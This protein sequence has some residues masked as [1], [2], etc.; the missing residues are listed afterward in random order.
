MSEKVTHNHYEFNVD[1]QFNILATVYIDW[2]P[3]VTKVRS[4]QP[5]WEKKIPMEMKDF[6]KQDFK[7]VEHFICSNAKFSY[8]MDTLHDNFILGEKKHLDK[9]EFEGRCKMLHWHVH[10]VRVNYWLAAGPYR[11][12]FRGKNYSQHY[13][14][15]TDSVDGEKKLVKDHVR[16]MIFNHTIL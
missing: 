16:E 12:D 7:K 1:E 5:A 13:N 11:N 10:N 6:S 2:K 8:S 4:F 9:S 14:Y 15:T 3:L